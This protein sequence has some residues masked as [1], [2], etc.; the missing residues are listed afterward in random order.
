MANNPADDK[1][2]KQY[3]VEY[4]IND[5][6][7]IKEYKEL[8]RPFRE[9]FRFTI[10]YNTL[11]SI[12]LFFYFKKATYYG[13]KFYPNRRRGLHNLILISTIH[14]LLFTGLLFGGNCLMLGINP[15]TFSKKYKELDRKM[16]QKDPYYQITQLNEALDMFNTIRDKNKKV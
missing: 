3:L 4:F 16:I 13:E 5:E 14:A 9:R 11:L 10:Y 8:F 1:Y 2:R 15:I 6:D 12:A 7:I